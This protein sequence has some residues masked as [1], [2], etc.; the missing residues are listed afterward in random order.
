MLRPL[1]SVIIPCYNDHLYIADAIRS[2]YDQD[3]EN[4]EIIIVDDGS[5]AK[6]KDVLKIL[7]KEKLDI[8]TQKNL[9]PA[10]ARNN[11]ISLA[12]GDYIVT[13]DA[14]DYFKPGFF[15]KALS[16]LVD[17]PDVGLVTSY[18]YAFSDKGIHWKIDL[19]EGNSEDFLLKNRALASCMYRKKC[20]REISGYDELMLD[21]FEDWDF[22][23][24]L[25]KAGWK[26]KVIK[27][28][29]FCYRIK[30]NSRNEIAEDMHKYKLL[31]YIYSKHQDVFFKNFDRMIVHFLDQMENLEKQKLEIKQTTTYRL[32]NFLLNP[33]KWIKTLVR[34][35]NK[36]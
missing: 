34:H 8:I 15:K 16:I 18:A 33:F 6:T 1:I 2:I 28:Y 25:T 30:S 17:H 4:I 31:K 36:A 12:K 35:R 32:G 22:N 19:K 7:E 9:G 27:E 11:G 14:D 20:W 29:L 10:A 26:V 23:I 24:S 5:D 13:L 3:Y 21:G